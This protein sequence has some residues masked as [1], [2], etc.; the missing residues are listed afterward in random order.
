MFFS[1]TG[2]KIKRLNLQHVAYSSSGIV[3]TDRT[4]I[5]LFILEEQG[6]FGEKDVWTG[7]MNQRDHFLERALQ[8]QCF[9]F[10]TI[11]LFLLERKA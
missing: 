1:F 10:E 5:C 9:D 6:G 7:M 11:K 3:C 4:E 2:A 8:N